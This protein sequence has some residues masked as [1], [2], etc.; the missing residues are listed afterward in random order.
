M[1]YILQV[2]FPYTGPWGNEMTKAMEGL[3]RSIAEEPG[4]IWKIWTVN[5]TTNEAGGIYL[6]S[7]ISAAKA[8][9]AM[10]TARLKSFGIPHVNGKIFLVNE[11]LSQLDRA[12]I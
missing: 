2:D 10:H 11:A 3:A 12:P 7:D 8:Y 4:L 6:F 5:E 9:L 1:S